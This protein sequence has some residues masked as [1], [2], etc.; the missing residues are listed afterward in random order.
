MKVF[1]TQRNK[2]GRG[3]SMDPSS[4]FFWI[5][6]A[7]D[8]QVNVHSPA[9]KIKEATNLQPYVPGFSACHTMANV[10]RA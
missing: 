7:D 9:G 8:E 3:N 4:R 2:F 5:S 6:C 1:A 10:L